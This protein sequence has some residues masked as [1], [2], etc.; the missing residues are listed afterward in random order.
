M[1]FTVRFILFGKGMT[2][3]IDADNEIQAKQIV[4]DR[5]KFCSVERISPFDDRL[6]DILKGKIWT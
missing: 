4:K 3:D 1:I 5:I 2:V 6:M